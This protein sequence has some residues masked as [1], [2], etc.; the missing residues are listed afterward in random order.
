MEQLWHPAGISL[1]AGCSAVSSWWE[2]KWWGHQWKTRR[3]YL[4]HL[5]YFVLLC[6]VYFISFHF[7]LFHFSNSNY[8]FDIFLII[9]LGAWI[10]GQMLFWDP[11][12]TAQKAV[13]HA[14]TY[15]PVV[16]PQAH[17]IRQLGLTRSKPIARVVIGGPLCSFPLWD[18]SNSCWLCT[19]WLSFSQ[20]KTDFLS[21]TKP[22]QQTHQYLH[23]EKKRA[24]CLPPGTE[25]CHLYAGKDLEH[26]IL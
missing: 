3:K 14:S 5:L 2:D 20:W 21:F 10:Q 22:L 19:G 24:L 25:S 1:T 18:G 11:G 12:V 23:C 26:Q 15:R 4:E 17:S 8:S 9:C 7:I 6:C 16:L 13:W